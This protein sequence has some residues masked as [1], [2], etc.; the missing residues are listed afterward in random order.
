MSCLCHPQTGPHGSPSQQRRELGTATRPAQ[1]EW[2]RAALERTSSPP[3]K[4]DPAVTE[5]Q[6]HPEK[7]YRFSGW[8]T[9]R[10]QGYQELGRHDQLCPQLC[11][12]AKS[13][14]EKGKEGVKVEHQQPWVKARSEAGT[15]DSLPAALR[16][17]AVP[18]RGE[19]AT[20][21]LRGR[22]LPGA[23]TGLWWEGLM[24]SPSRCPRQGG[25][26]GRSTQSRLR[27]FAFQS[28]GRMITTRSPARAPAHHAEIQKVFDH[29]SGIFLCI[30]LSKILFP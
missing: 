11:Q 28:P 1:R 19:G 16:D 4:G 12:E 21:P 5:P 9:R 15:L 18:G 30:Y 25:A 2:S 13:G 3:C 27:V 20:H 14:H 23:G 22:A 6:Q 24:G 10:H 7:G 8:K 26:S 17:V 29:V